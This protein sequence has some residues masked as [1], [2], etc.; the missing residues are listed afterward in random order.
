[1]VC[2]NLIMIPEAIKH[3]TTKAGNRIDS[4]LSRKRLRSSAG[5]LIKART[6]ER[7]IDELAS[8]GII[9]LNRHCECLYSNPG[10]H[11]L[12]GIN[13]QQSRGDKWLLAI[14]SDDQEA[15]NQAC[16]IAVGDKKKY[17]IDCR[18][19][20][21]A[22]GNSQTWVRFEANPIHDDKGHFVGCLGTF[23]DITHQK[24]TTESLLQ[25]SLYDPLTK[26]PNRSL[27]MQ[28][29]QTA[30]E[31]GNTPPSL[32]LV[33]IDLDG[34][35]LIN[36]TLGQSVG[37]KLIL[38]VSQR[39]ENCLK[40]TD[41][42]ARPGGDE[43]TVIVRDNTA[44]GRAALLA[45]NILNAIKR[46]ITIDGD[47]VYISASVGI[48]I[49]KAGV[50][51]DKLAQ[52]ASVA[53]YNAKERQGNAIQFHNHELTA[54]NR[55]ELIVSGQL[56]SAL[57]NNEFSVY[58]QP[59]LDIPDNTI[60]GSE[61]LLRWKNPLLG[62]IP[63]GVF[64]P[65]LEAR[66]LII[67]VGEWV[68][69]QACHMQAQWHRDYSGMNATVSV[70]VSSIQLRDRYFLNKLK[71]ILD[72]STLPPDCLVL[73]LTETVLLDEFVS[74]TNLLH[75][76]SALGVKIA[77]DDFGTGYGS[78]SYLK[79]HPID[80]IKIDQSFIKNLFDGEANKAITNSIIDLSHKLGKTV[81]AEGVDKQEVLDCLMMRGCDIYQ[82]FLSSRALPSA[83]FATRFLQTKQYA[84]SKI[85][86]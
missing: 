12:S 37:N 76:I 65:L 8:P 73:E 75:K 82:G 9:L 16:R 7:I 32:A 47:T 62:T 11:Q 80:H 19:R 21:P 1:M 84:E 29:L 43:F 59:Q 30:L 46:P 49:A 44:S 35:K 33:F 14:H 60:C 69:A 41:L 64:I 77:I 15:A 31:T 83:D 40:P 51:A 55:A 48:A 26:L 67:P 61:A 78:F 56:H 5:H 36:D 38:E 27:L 57:D 3:H 66:G 10:W 54:K 45:G 70:N 6:L 39:I 72:S 13:P 58:Y 28:R 68:L 52:Q 53:M 63:P 42:L 85:A 4:L 23:T 79:K 22:G 18:L 20:Q 24:Q 81:I 34:F 25:L 86:C 74:E 17:H 2:P 50:T 71:D